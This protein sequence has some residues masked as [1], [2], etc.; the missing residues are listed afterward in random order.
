[1]S[2]KDSVKKFFRWCSFIQFYSSIFQVFGLI[3][4]SSSEA[5]I[6]QATIPIFTLLSAS[7]F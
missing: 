3:C 6:I 7:L 1:M 4:T 5:G 2:A